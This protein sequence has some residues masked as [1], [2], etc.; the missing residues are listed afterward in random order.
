MNLSPQAL[1]KYLMLLEHPYMVR[2]LQPKQA[3]V[4][5]AVDKAYPLKLKVTTI[6]L[7]IAQRDFFQAL[8]G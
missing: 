7:A 6:H 5:A 4:L 8:E 1:K 2:L 3:W